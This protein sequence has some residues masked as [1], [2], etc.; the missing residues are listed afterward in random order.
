MDGP[1]KWLD[2]EWRHEHSYGPRESND[3]EHR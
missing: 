3:V 2:E 1:V